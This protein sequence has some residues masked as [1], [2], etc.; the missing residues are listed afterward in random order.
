M[1]ESFHPTHSGTIF[2][3]AH[4]C[5]SGPNGAGWPENWAVYRGYREA[6]HRVQ[7]FA[8]RA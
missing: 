3:G 6:E 1:V 7:R 4:A 5:C 8:A 2:Y